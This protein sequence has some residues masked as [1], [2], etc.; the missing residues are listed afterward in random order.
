MAHDVLRKVLGLTKSQYD[1]L[2]DDIIHRLSER[3]IRAMD[4]EI[5][6][7][8]RGIVIEIAKKEFKQFSEMK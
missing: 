3:D 5:L 2:L 4:K 1:D 8:V 7:I 6:G